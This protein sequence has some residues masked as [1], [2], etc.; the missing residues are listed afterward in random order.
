MR[1]MRATAD[2]ECGAS[3]G[4]EAVPRGRERGIVV[5]CPPLADA[6]GRRRHDVVMWRC[7][8]TSKLVGALR[9]SGAMAPVATTTRIGY[10]ISRRHEWPVLAR[11]PLLAQVRPCIVLVVTPEKPLS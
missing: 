8:C 2:P 9:A 6:Q 5:E 3:A 10:Q 7:R 4:W 1:G 11:R